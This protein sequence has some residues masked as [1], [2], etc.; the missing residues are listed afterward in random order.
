MI[1]F[2]AQNQFATGSGFLNLPNGL[3]F[4]GGGAA[5]KQLG[6]EAL[7]I[8]TAGAAGGLPWPAA[9]RRSTSAVVSPRC[10]PVAVRVI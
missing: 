2:F 3:L 7:G 5:I 9:R 4:G 10:S 6:I 1:A 8:V